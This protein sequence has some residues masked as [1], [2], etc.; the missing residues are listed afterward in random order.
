MKKHLQFL[1]LLAV[2]FVAMNSK[3]DVV[4]FTHNSPGGSGVQT[5]TDYL[6]PS[7][8]SAEV[9]TSIM[10]GTFLYFVKDGT[11]F[12]NAGGTIAG[13]AIVRMRGGIGPAKGLV[14]LRIT[15]EAFPPDRT[16]IIAPSTNL[17]N[18]ALECS[19]NLVN[20]AS[21]TNGVYGGSTNAAKFFRIK[22]DKLN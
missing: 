9:L 1:S 3:G 18:I 2:F 15:P 13:P 22:L 10:A 17:F 11:E 21:A 4:T 5:N 19:T 20:W 16:I 6:I 14:T 8:V 7:G 12:A